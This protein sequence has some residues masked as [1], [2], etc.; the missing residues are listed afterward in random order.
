MREDTAKIAILR[1]RVTLAQKQAVC[2][3]AEQIGHTESHV[4]RKCIEYGLPELV[5][6][7]TNVQPV[8]ALDAEKEGEE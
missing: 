2:R 1:A 6:T 4:V 8:A 7:L 3:F 5:A